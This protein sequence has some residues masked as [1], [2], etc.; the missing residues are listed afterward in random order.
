MVQFTIR[1]NPTDRRQR[2]VLARQ[3]KG[4]SYMGVR[5]KLSETYRTDVNFDV[6]DEKGK[7][8]TSASPRSSSA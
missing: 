5:F 7:P 2:R 6:L 8:R 4:R 1:A 3:P